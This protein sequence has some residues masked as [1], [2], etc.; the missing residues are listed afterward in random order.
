MCI[1]T[2]VHKSTAEGNFCDEYKRTRKPAIVAVTTWATSKK[3]T[4]WLIAIQL[5]GEHRS[6]QRD[7]SPAGSNNIE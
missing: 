4:E 1:L 6:G 5:V 2:N 3:G 7:F